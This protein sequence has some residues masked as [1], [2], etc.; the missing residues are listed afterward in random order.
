M[1]KSVRRGDKVKGRKGQGK[2][3]NAR[4]MEGGRC[5]GITTKHTNSRKVKK[6]SRKGR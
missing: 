1:K 6:N 3:F 5:R 2:C 4:E